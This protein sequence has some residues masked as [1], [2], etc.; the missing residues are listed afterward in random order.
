MTVRAYSYMANVLDLAKRN[1]SAAQ[2]SEIVP[3]ESN[4]FLS[5][6]DIALTAAVMVP[7]TAIWIMSERMWPAVALGS[8]IYLG[9]EYGYPA[10]RAQKFDF[11]P[12]IDSL[13]RFYH[14]ARTLVRFRNTSRA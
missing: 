10:F 8:I 14:N 13:L 7:A 2:A 6:R 1:I 11:Q 9:I 12:L 4:E 5:S 3:M